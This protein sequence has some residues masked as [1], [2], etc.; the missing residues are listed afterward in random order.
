M[1]WVPLYRSSIRVVDVNA[2]QQQQQRQSFDNAF[3]GGSY[4]TAT[5]SAAP[6]V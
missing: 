5:L 6:F 1:P 4:S 3:S 2:L